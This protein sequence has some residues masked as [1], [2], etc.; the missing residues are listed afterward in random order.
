MLTKTFINAHDNVLY[1]LILEQLTLDS[2]TFFFGI[3]KS[4][5]NWKKKWEYDSDSCAKYYLSIEKK[6]EKRKKT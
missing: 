6:K 4:F 5:V 3:I 2:I 1:C